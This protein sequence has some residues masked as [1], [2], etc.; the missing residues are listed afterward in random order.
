MA[1]DSCST[2]HL[3][4]ILKQPRVSLILD[5]MLLERGKTGRRQRILGLELLAECAAIGMLCCG[6]IFPGQQPEVE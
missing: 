4:R 1:V 5:D 3:H 6:L 2:F